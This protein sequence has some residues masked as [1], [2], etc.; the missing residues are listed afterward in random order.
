MD[1]IF[2][3]KVDVSYGEGGDSGGGDDDGDSEK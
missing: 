1:I 2:M 3:I